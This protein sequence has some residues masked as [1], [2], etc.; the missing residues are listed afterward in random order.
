MLVSIIIDNYNY[1]QFLPKAIDSALA[2]TY[3]HIEIIVVD[4]GSTDNSKEILEDYKERVQVFQKPNGGQASAFA[5]GLQQSRGEIIFFLDSDDVMYPELI[6]RVV[7]AWRP[8]YCKIQFKLDTIDTNGRNLNMIFPH[9]AQDLTPAEIRRQS[10]KFGIYSWP[11]TLG[12]A[13]SRAYLQQVLPFPDMVTYSPDSYLNKM[14]PLYGD[15]GVL[16]AVLGGYRVHGQNHWASDTIKVSK[17]S[18]FLKLDD[19]LCDIFSKAALTRGYQIDGARQRVNR[20]NLETRL[21]SLRLAPKLHPLPRDNIAKAL[22][23]GWVSA[24]MSPGLTFLG[25]VLWSLWFAGLAV[26]PARIIRFLLSHGRAQHYRAS[27]FSRLIQWSRKSKLNTP[28]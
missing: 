6:A 17:Y 14:A 9:Y 10:L 4:D 26:L 23:D 18:I 13:Y 11:V 15:V 2:Q 28:N 24:W 3:S 21:L 8:A 27:L 19:L 12:N 22:G 5:F 7:E 25:R 20:S 1:A 16:H